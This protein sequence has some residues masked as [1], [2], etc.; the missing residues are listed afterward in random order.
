MLPS[1][2][3]KA[4]LQVGRQGDVGSI[5]MQ[6]LLL[7]SRGP[8]AGLIVIE[9]NVKAEKPGSA[10]LWGKQASIPPFLILTRLSICELS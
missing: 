9:W 5:E 4:M 7:T 8:T 10:G 3:P 6:D 2:K 1:R